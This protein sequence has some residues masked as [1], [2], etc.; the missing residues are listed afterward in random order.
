MGANTGQYADLV[1]SL[2]YRG[3]IVSFEPQSEASGVLQKRA[4][5]T[6]DWDVRP[7]ALGPTSGTATLRIS[8]NSVSSSLLPIGDEHVRA[9]P[10]SSVISHEDVKV[11]T[12]DDELTGVP[13]RAVWLKLDVQGTELPIL[14]GG[15][16]TLARTVAVQSEMSLR[17]LYEGQTDY[18][19]L[20]AHL[21]EQGLV[22]CHILPGFTDSGSGAL[23]QVDGLFLRL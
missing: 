13:G 4:M 16:E 1:R 10:K 21:R 19:E 12:L 9:A 22:L 18:L 6:P 2:G 15:T 20:C 14:L 5:R 8:R 17:G 3:T 11:S 23:L 7:V